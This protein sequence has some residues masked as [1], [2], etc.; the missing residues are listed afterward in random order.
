MPYSIPSPVPHV[1]RALRALVIVMHVTHD[2][3][4]TLLVNMG[5]MICM[6]K[7]NI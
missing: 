6:L 3:C 5:E 4:E 7:K 1:P 2:K